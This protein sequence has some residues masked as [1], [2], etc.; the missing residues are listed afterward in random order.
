MWSQPIILLQIYSPNF[1]KFWVQ[2]DV[3]NG[4]YEQQD[5]EGFRRAE[6][7]STRAEKKAHP[8]LVILEKDEIET[9][10]PGVDFNALKNIKYRTFVRAVLEASHPRMITL[11]EMQLIWDALV[12]KLFRFECACTKESKANEVRYPY[13]HKFN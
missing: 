3:L 7:D 8:G 2:R 4:T 13:L 5:I 1:N 12:Y 11:A 6:R 10:V 9:L